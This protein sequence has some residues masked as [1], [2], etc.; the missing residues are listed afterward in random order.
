M[1]AI[2]LDHLWLACFLGENAFSCPLWLKLL[3]M[4]DI[5]NG[6]VEL[7]LPMNYRIAS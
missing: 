2:N 1:L 3:S 5:T 4:L 7:K 6:S